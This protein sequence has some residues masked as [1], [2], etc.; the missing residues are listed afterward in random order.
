MLRGSVAAVVLAAGL[1]AV[2]AGAQVIDLGKYPDWSGQWNRV[3][4]GGPPRYDPTKPLRKQEAP[5]KPEY[6]VKYQQSLNDIDIGGLG[7]DTHYA[8]MPHGMPRQMSGISLMEFLFSPSVTHILFEDMTAATRRIYT[9][10]RPWPKTGEPTFSGYSIGKWLDTDNDDRFDTLEIE[11][12]NIRG[13]RTWDQ[14][15]M[16]IAEDN[17]GVIHERLYLD[18]TNKNIMHNEMTTIDNSLT[19]PWTVTKNYRRRENVSWE[20]NN[21]VENNTYLTINKEVYFVGADGLLMPLKKGQAG[22]D[23]RHF[24]VK[25]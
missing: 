7:L 16:P 13:P 1:W 6:Q 8:C 15:G 22:P 3:P 17:E 24:D 23:L 10:G 11:T 12:R 14:T 19:R 4:D 25:K 9:D 5:F 20:E 18:K 21:C 2:P